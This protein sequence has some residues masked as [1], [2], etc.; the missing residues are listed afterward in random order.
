MGCLQ[1]LGALLLLPFGFWGYLQGGL[2]GASTGLVGVITVGSGLAIW[3]G[4]R[5]TAVSTTDLLERR[6][7]QTGGIVAT[8]ASLAGCLYGGWTWGWAW[9]AAGFLLGM[10]TSVVVGMVL[11][12]GRTT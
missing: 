3:A 2:A 11:T 7:H 1:S 4:E 9:A 10:L 12:T 8:V 5:G 6:A